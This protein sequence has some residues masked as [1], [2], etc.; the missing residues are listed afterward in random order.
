MERTLNPSSS[1]QQCTSCGGAEASGWC[2]ECV[3]A[4]CEE[5][6]S[7]HRRV[8]MTRSHTIQ[9]QNPAGLCAP[10]SRFCQ[11]HSSEPL[12]LFCFPCSQLT[13]RDCQLLSHRNHRFQ[14]VPEALDSLKQQLDSLLQP[15]RAQRDTAR[16]TLLDMDGRL[17]DITAHKSR[18]R[19]ALKRTFALFVVRLKEQVVNLC[20]A[21]ERVYQPEVE[22]VEQRTAALRLLEEKQQLVTDR[23]E[24]ARSS[25][26]LPSL[27]SCTSQIEAQLEEL[28]SQDASPPQSMTH[29]KLWTSETSY[30]AIL[31][32]GELSV[33]TVPFS[34]SPADP[35]NSSSAAPL[36]NGAAPVSASSRSSPSGPHT[37]TCS[38]PPPYRLLPQAGGAGDTGPPD[39]GSHLSAS[40]QSSPNQSWPAHS[41]CSSLYQSNPPVTTPTSVY[42]APVA[43]FPQT[44]S[45]AETNLLL[46]NRTQS[47][48]F[49]LSHTQP[50]CTSVNMQGSVQSNYTQPCMAA[51]GP[52]H[53]SVVPQQHPTPAS[54]VRN[55]SQ[56]NPN[57]NPHAQTL[58]YRAS[59]RRPSTFKR[60]SSAVTQHSM[61]FS[62]APAF[63]LPANCYQMAV[64][65]VSLSSMDQKNYVQSENVSVSHSRFSTA[66]VSHQQHSP[67]ESN[68]QLLNI[69]HMQSS[70]ATVNY[71]QTSLVPAYQMTQVVP[72]QL[73]PSSAAPV[74]DR[75]SPAAVKRRNQ[76]GNAAS[77]SH[78]LP[79]GAM[80]YHWKLPAGQS[81]H[82]QHSTAP[83]DQE[84][85]CTVTPPFT[86]SA[87]VKDKHPI[88]TH[89][90]L[91]KSTS[92]SSKETGTKGGKDKTPT[93]PHHPTSDADQPLA[94]SHS[95]SSL[96]HQHPTLT[97]KAV[98]DSAC[99]RSVPQAGEPPAAS[100]PEPGENEPTSTVSETETT[101]EGDRP[102][103]SELSSAWDD[104]NVSVSDSDRT[105]SVGKT[106]EEPV[107][108]A[109]FGPGAAADAKTPPEAKSCSATVKREAELVCYDDVA[110]LIFQYL[111]SSAQTQLIK[112]EPATEEE[113]GETDTANAVR[114]DFSPSTEETESD[115]SVGRPFSVTLQE[116]N[117]LWKPSAAYS[118]RELPSRE[119]DSEELCCVDGHQGCR[120]NPWQ[121]RVSLV[122]LPISTPLPGQPPPRFLLLPGEAKDEIHLQQIDEDNQSHVDDIMDFLEPLSSPET[123]PLQQAASCSACRS[124]SSCVSC[125]ACGR[126]FHR[127]CHIPA[128]GPNAGWD[129]VCSLCQDLSDPTDPYSSDRRRTSCLSL[130]D[131]R[132]CEHL[133]L[134]LMCDDSSGV[135]RP[136]ELSGGS[137]PL[138]L[139]AERLSHRRSPPYRTPAEFV[140]DI[141]LLFEVVPNTEE[142]SE[143]LTQLQESFQTKLAELFGAELHPS[144]LKRCGT[145]SGEAGGRAA[146]AGCGNINILPSNSDNQAELGDGAEEPEGSKV[147]TDAKSGRMKTGEAA[148]VEGSKA[149]THLNTRLTGGAW[150]EAEEGEEVAEASEG[151]KVTSDP[152]CGL[153]LEGEGPPAEEAKLK[154]T[155][156]RLK[157]FLLMNC[158][159]PKKPKTDQMVE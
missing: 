138:S 44:S 29:L 88:L 78:T 131:Q 124:A 143:V 144:L 118:A 148:E 67:V 103:P 101:G 111:S 4:L 59:H 140:S 63:T 50:V 23:A 127:A 82:S 134:Y 35:Q 86:K 47:T 152:D 2:V 41:S 65:G 94:F 87:D 62:Q 58:M 75:S 128:V 91:R 31:S 60:C 24:E 69:N 149:P 72:V 64:V 99:D 153:T 96:Q 68:L 37:S 26:S 49:P 129:W 48:P 27:L 150:P 108:S 93:S 42:P 107:P 106:A 19:E 122:R 154:E 110:S 117:P 10:A 56:S 14:F 53:R 135:R 43:Q 74:Q 11:I 100:R 119:A 66:S 157:E 9:N 116:T 146:A 105:L 151:S 76:P 97:V 36:E 46:A 18:L 33:S 136:A 13:C 71:S 84:Q 39:P 113:Q 123:P 77:G 15:I 45:H 70:T 158:W 61:P 145:R 30:K 114:L 115:W 3:E 83:L 38:A 156:K 130:L 51:A 132:K 92:S 12:Q 1:G 73:E 81:N 6:V 40:W 120:V 55:R 57:P 8:K 25:D 139:T 126:G 32:F 5:C 112:Q 89:H 142:Q 98:A 95:S 7:A 90:L 104:T 17:Q 133:L 20:R 16:Q 28:L 54:A 121:P 109:G 85:T 21:I 159:S 80:Y 34:R 147:A 137:S 79:N 52:S 102:V 125:A 155:R 141:W 22:G